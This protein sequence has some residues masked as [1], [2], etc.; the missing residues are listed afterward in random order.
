VNV[1]DNHFISDFLFLDK[2]YSCFQVSTELSFQDR[3]YVFNELT[4]AIFLIIELL[5]HFLSVF[6][7]DNLIVPGT[8]RDEG[9][10]LKI[11]TD[12]TMYVFGIVTFIHDVTIGFPYFM[13]L[14]KEFFCMTGIVDSGIG[15][16]KSCDSPKIGIDRDRSF[17]EM[18]PNLTGSGRIIMAAITAG[19]A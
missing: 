15:C 19:K 13:A 3:E 6:P 7:T 4:S 16:D 5:S 10:C 12:K 14:S 9:F 17:E 8:D 1:T 18:F 2:K 11:F